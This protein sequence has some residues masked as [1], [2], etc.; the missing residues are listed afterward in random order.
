MNSHRY[1]RAERELKAAR[2]YGEGAVQFYERAEVSIYGQHA[3][4]SSGVHGHI[5]LLTRIEESI[6][7][8]FGHI[9]RIDD[10]RFAEHNYVGSV[11]G[12]VQ[13]ESRNIFI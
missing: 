10:R 3:N 5:V 12:C 11:N 7:S 8:W 6:L 2:P 4:L 9:E 1:S 13:R